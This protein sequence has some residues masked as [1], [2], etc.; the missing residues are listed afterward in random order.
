MADKELDLDALMD[1][2]AI[3]I[4]TVIDDATRERVGIVA[5]H[6]FTGLR[7]AE[8]LVRLAMQRG[9]YSPYLRCDNRPEMRAAAVSQWSLINQLRV[10][11]I[12]P[13]K[14][15]RNDFCESF[16][17]TLRAECLNQELCI[18]EPAFQRK[19]DDSPREHNEGRPHSSIGISTTPRGCK[20][21]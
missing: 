9:A 21:T 14:P 6:F 1:G 20:T 4:L 13:G 15:F 8:A 11:F 16:N 7:L 5:G 17:G 10:I 3:R 2:R 12:E 19:L 18:S